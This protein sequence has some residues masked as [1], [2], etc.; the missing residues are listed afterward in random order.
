[1]RYFLSLRR[2]DFSVGHN[3][4]CTM[5]VWSFT[6]VK[7]P[8][9]TVDHPQHLAQILN[10]GYSYNPPS[11]W[12]FMCCSRVKFNFFLLDTTLKSI[13]FHLKKDTDPHPQKR[14]LYQKTHSKSHVILSI[15]YHRHN[16]WNLIVSKR[17]ESIG[18]NL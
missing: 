15:K 13:P 16:L 1:M 9:C 5:S 17:R 11:L 10:K 8:G 12:P 18:S 2:I 14:F 4:F 7:R 6:G 3:A